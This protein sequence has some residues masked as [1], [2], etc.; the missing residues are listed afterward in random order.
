[1]WK[2]KTV[3]FQSLTIRK[4]ELI[5]IIHSRMW[6]AKRMYVPAGTKFDCYIDDGHERWY[7][8]VYGIEGMDANWARKYL[9]DIRPVVRKKKKL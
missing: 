4:R 3:W 7:D 6:K 9:R 5:R 2:S 8:T 1:M